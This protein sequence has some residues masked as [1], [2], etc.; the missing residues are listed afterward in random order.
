MAPLGRLK[1]MQWRYWVGTQDAGT[2]GQ[3]GRTSFLLLSAADAGLESRSA[4]GSTASMAH[5][6]LLER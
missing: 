3:G 6:L 4:T 5:S 1:P 2:V